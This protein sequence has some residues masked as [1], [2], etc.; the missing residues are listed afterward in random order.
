MVWRKSDVRVWENADVWVND[1]VKARVRKISIVEEDDNFV[2]TQFDKRG[3]V[4]VS[5]KIESLRSA[6][7]RVRELLR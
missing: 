6:F 7:E 1:D 4:L 5:E 3:K 2:V